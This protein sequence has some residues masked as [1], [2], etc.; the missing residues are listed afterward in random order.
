MA[1][2]PDLS[3]YMAEIDN[4]DNTID[5]HEFIKCLRPD[6]LGLFEPL[7]GILLLNVSE[8]EF[9]AM[10]ARWSKN[11]CTD[12][13][14]DLIR[15]I[16]HET[17]H[18]MQT[19]CS[20][21]MY[22]R[23]CAA[24]SIFNGDSVLSDDAVPADSASGQLLKALEGLET[25]S[26]EYQRLSAVTKLLRQHEDLGKIA[27]NAAPGDNSYFGGA[28]P[29][30]FAHLAALELAENETNEDG[31][32]ILSI[33]EGTAVA[34]AQLLMGGT[35][36]FEAR[37]EAECSTLPP[38]YSALYR[39]TQGLCGDRTSELLLPAAS[40]ALMCERPDRAYI[41]ILRALID[42]PSHDVQQ[43]APVVADRLDSLPGVGT[44]LG[45]AV[46]VRSQYP[47]YL[48]YKPVLDQIESNAWGAHPF[49]LLADPAT[50]NGV[51]SFPMGFL[52]RD[53][54]RGGGGLDR[55]IL[56]ARMF[57]MSVVLRVRS[58]R[59]TEKAVRE[60]LGAWA[61]GVLV[62]LTGG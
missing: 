55:D 28:F 20:G 48:V 32:S 30:F 61:Q 56:I 17:Y 37:M 58:R 41:P 51:P 13:D 38:V 50:M 60:Q 57:L 12:S 19:V 35:V 52:T 39:V 11:E 62:R 3:T 14:I 33:I 34:H 2:S 26:P 27:A 8:D 7:S 15:T 18:F 46:D 36:G 22:K 44:V 4:T 59:R 53:G 10:A 49:W 45:F 23:Q 21:Y 9:Q 31:L 24:F 47:D 54:F 43:D 5:A 25:A 42:A 6:Q 1:G 16:N 40:M 29:K